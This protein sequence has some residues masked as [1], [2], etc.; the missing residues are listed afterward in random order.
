MMQG[1]RGSKGG[2]VRRGMKQMTESKM[3]TTMFAEPR[4]VAFMT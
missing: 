1:D 2:R 4:A 3:E